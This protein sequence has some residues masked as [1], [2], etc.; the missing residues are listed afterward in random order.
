MKGLM[1]GFNPILKPYSKGIFHSLVSGYNTVSVIKSP[2]IA[3]LKLLHIHFPPEFSSIWKKRVDNSPFLNGWVNLIFSVAC[4]S[5]SKFLVLGISW[6]QHGDHGKCGLWSHRNCPYSLRC[7][8]TQDPCGGVH[9]LKLSGLE[10]P[11]LKMGWEP[12]WGSQEIM[13]VMTGR[14]WQVTLLDPSLPR[15]FLLSF[16]ALFLPV[17]RTRY[18]LVKSRMNIVAALSCCNGSHLW[19]SVGK[20]SHITKFSGTMW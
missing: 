8:F 7:S 12:P 2:L 9:A 3:N 10:F 20:V 15:P 5:L 4:V 13:K 16:L 6:K 14:R 17:R 19:D 18:I 1:S 11:D